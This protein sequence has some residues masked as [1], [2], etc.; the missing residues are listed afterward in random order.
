MKEYL[1]KLLQALNIEANEASI[2]TLLLLQSVFLGIFYGALDT[3]SNSLFLG[4]FPPDML[5]KAFTIS[6]V[7]GIIMT[8]IYSSLQSKMQFK[9]LAILNLFVVALL[10]SLLW[11]GF[12]VTTSKWHVFA[13]LVLMG[14]LNIIAMIGFWGTAGR[15]FSLRQGKRLFGLVDAGQIIGVI[16]SSYAVPVILSFN[17]KTKDI[18]LISAVSALVALVFQIVISGQTSS[19]G[20]KA[21]KKEEKEPEKSFLSLFKNP[22]VR[23]MSIFVALSMITAFFISFSFLAVTKA[24]YPD[25]DEMAKF[26]GVFVGTIMFFTLLIKTL[27]YGRFMKTYGLRTSLVLSPAVL[28]ILSLVAVLIG[29][30]GGYT[31]T[32]GGFIFFFLIIALSRL[33][34][35]ALKSSIEAPSFKILYQTVDV[36]IRHNVQ[37]RVDGTVNEI[38]ALTSGIVLFV[39]G[40][41]S[42]FT[43]IH[44]T[45]VLVVL[46]V[47]W[48]FV[49]YKL[50]RAYK[51]NLDE[52][53]VKLKQH[54][55]VEISKKTTGIAATALNGDENTSKVVYIMNLQE[56]VQPLVYERLV[57]YLLN[58]KLEPVQKY[59]LERISNLKLYEGIDAIKHIDN[60]SFA[61]ESKKIAGELTQEL[62]EGFANERIVTL[63]RSKVSSDRE[64]AARLIGESRNAEYIHHLK[65]LLRDFDKQ[66]KIAAIKASAKIKS[67]EL[68][69][70]I[71]EFLQTDYGKYAYDSLIETG[72]LVIEHLEHIFSKSGNEDT[73]SYKIVRIIGTVG[74]EKAT[75]SLVHK[76]NYHNIHIARLAAKLLLSLKYTFSEETYYLFHQSLMQAINVEAWNIAARLSL[77]ESTDDVLLK[78]AIEQEIHSGYDHIFTLLSLAYNAQTI[79]HV[80]Q[81]IESESAESTGYAMELLEL[82]VS[83]DIKPTLFPL[84]DDSSDSEKVKL[85]Q[86]FFPIDRISLNELLTDIV[87]RDCNQLNTWTKACAL[88]YILK[89]EIFPVSDDFVAQ[90]FNQDELISELATL[91]IHKNA[92][93][94][95]VKCFK[96]IDEKNRIRL[97]TSIKNYTSEPDHLII[98]KMLYLKE[99]DFLKSVPA[100]RLYF[101]AQRLGIEKYASGDEIES[102]DEDFAVKV[103]ML[104]DGVVK[105]Q[106]FEGNEEVINQKT[107]FGGLFSHGYPK[108]IPSFFADSDVVC[109]MIYQDVFDRVMF[110]YPEFAE[111]LVMFNPIEKV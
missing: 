50:Y 34:S 88:F 17:I 16:L 9:N 78:E 53:L 77:K 40:S 94:S 93:E 57:P 11:A 21:F 14:P 31:T 95:I 105:M 65:F 63:T 71:A 35:V 12:S 10:T 90:M 76:I 68:C 97:N 100:D 23:L 1:R 52:S 15:I 56:K 39:L 107:V 18:L 75:K 110:D 79:S 2:V 89:L 64:L 25:M 70:V 22:F 36:K 3:A 55:K 96:R 13:L 81:N 38:S 87:N 24:K 84:I 30:I 47:A 104:V 106:S 5:P 28:I 86:N 85:L 32:A 41:L 43:L 46:L 45:E 27:V 82:V 69:P 102:V 37:A 99:L 111:G 109:Y 26:L 98:N 61:A 72:D 20:G 6:G 91:I 83:D 62:A 4:A 103:Y 60:V 29:V 58:H 80:R 19:L 73:L 42:F 51:N 7:A 44:F 66:V 74:G 49:A 67:A 8:S 92:P 108:Q 48:L 59:S 101:L 33:F 54:D